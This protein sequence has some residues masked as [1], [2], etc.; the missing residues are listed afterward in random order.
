MWSEDIQ[1]FLRDTYMCYGVDVVHLLPRRRYCSNT[2][3]LILIR[4][5]KAETTKQL[6]C[7]CAG[8]DARRIWICKDTQIQS[9]TQYFTMISKVCKTESCTVFLIQSRGYTSPVKW[10]NF[11][12]LHTYACLLICINEYMCVSQGFNYQLVSWK[13]TQDQ[14]EKCLQV[15]QQLVWKEASLPS[16]TASTETT[17]TL[18]TLL[19]TATGSTTTRRHM[20][21]TV[22]NCNSL[23]LEI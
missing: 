12:Y 15:F 23:Q 13:W 4:C 17:A 8:R 14:N 7:V 5:N 19:L 1:C 9:L 11:I 18:S 16:C 22:C 10:S 6:V 21:C 2:G 3:L 20:I